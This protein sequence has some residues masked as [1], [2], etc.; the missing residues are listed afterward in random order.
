[1]SPEEF[2]KV[3]IE[4]FGQRGIMEEEKIKERLHEIQQNFYNRLESKKLIKKHGKIPFTEHLSITHKKPVKLSENAAALQVNPD[5][6]REISFYNTTRENV[7]KG[8]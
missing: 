4:K 6:K 1:M 3:T 8:M 7:M 2:E 5:L